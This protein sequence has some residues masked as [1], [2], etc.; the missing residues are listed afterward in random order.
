[1]SLSCLNIDHK[2][3]TALTNSSTCNISEGP[4]QIIGHP[5]AIISAQ[6]KTTSAKNLE[7]KLLFAVENI[8]SRPLRGEHKI[9][10]LKIY[11]STIHSFS[12][13]G[14]CYL[15]QNN[16][17]EEFK[18][19]PPN[20]LKSDLMPYT[21]S[22]IS[23]SNFPFLPHLQKQAKLSMISAFKWPVYHRIS[24]PT[25]ISWICK[26]TRYIPFFLLSARSC[27]SKEGLNHDSSQTE[28]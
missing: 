16:V 24:S 4:T 3:N 17:W 9:W 23:T 22:S 2:S 14:R 12:P 19:S 10:I 11:F 7:S 20:S 25:E 8:E 13:D 6:S 28:S 21:G 26:S 18:V 27:D 5:T 15:Y 1:M